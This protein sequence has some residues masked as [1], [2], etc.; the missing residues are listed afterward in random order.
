M[1]TPRELSHNQA[2]RLLFS[3]EK[4]TAPSLLIMS[5]KG[6]QKLMILP[7]P[8]FHKC[9]AISPEGHHAKT[10]AFRRSTLTI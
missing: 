4:I 9:L 7:T 10:I 1:L 6:I 8:Y 3:S 5:S 2:I